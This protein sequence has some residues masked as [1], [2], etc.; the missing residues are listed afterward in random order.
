MRAKAITFV[1]A[2]IGPLMA[3]S[4]FP[5]ELTLKWKA[6]EVPTYWHNRLVLAKNS[7][8]VSSR[9]M[10]IGPSGAPAPDEADGLYI[11]KAET[12]EK[13]HL[14]TSKDAGGIA[15]SDIDG[16]NLPEALV[17]CY[18][19]SVY[20]YKLGAPSRP[21]KL[22]TG[23]LIASTPTVSDMDGDGSPEILVANSQG[24]L[25][26]F[27]PDGGLLWKYEEMRTAWIIS[28]PAVADLDGDA[29][30][31][32]VVG[33]S[34]GRNEG[35]LYCFN[36]QG[37]LL[38][39]F[40]ASGQVV[41][42]P[43]VGDIDKD[44][45][46]EIIFGS[47][48]HNLYCLNPDGSLRWKFPTG[49][50]ITSSPAL[51]DISPED[52]VEVMV[53]SKDSTV[54]CISSRGKK[55]WAFRT[56]GPVVSSPVVADLDGDGR[57][58]VVVGDLSGVIYVLGHFGIWKYE[59]DSEILS[60]P[61]VGDVDGD[62]KL[63]VV[64]PSKRTVYCFESPGA[65]RIAWAKFQGDSWNTGLLA[66]AITYGRF[67]ASGFPGTWTP[68]IQPVVVFS[69]PNLEEAIRDELG[70]PRGPITAK[71]LAEL[72]EL[73][74]SGRGIRDLSGI[75]RCINLRRLW[76]SGNEVEDIRP[77][78]ALTNL[79]ELYL[80]DNR[81][82]DIA[83][84]GNLTE[85]R[86][87]DLGDN[88]IE[89]VGSLKRLTNLRKLY[90]YNNSIE[91]VAPLAGLFGLK[92]L[93]LSNN[94]ISDIGPLANLTNLGALYLDD[95]LVQDI[96]PLANLRKIGEEGG[97]ERDG[98]VIHLGL[99]DNQITDIGP[100]LDNPGLGEGDGV[101]LRGN[102][103]G[104]ESVDI[105]RKL[106]AKGV[107]V[108]YEA[109]STAPVLK[110]PRQLNF[111]EVAVGDT[112]LR[113][114]EMANV[115]TDTLEVRKM[116][117]GRPTAEAR[118]SVFGLLPRPPLPWK[119]P[120]EGRKTIQLFFAPQR[121]GPHQDTLWVI[122]DDPAGPKGVA[123]IGMG[124]APEVVVSAGNVDFGPVQ[125][126]SYKDTLLSIYNRGNADLR[127]T[128][129]S[130]ASGEAFV[131]LQDPEG[132]VVSPDGSVPLR[133]RFLP[134]AV[135][136]F[137]DTIVIVT[138]APESPHK[139]PLAGEGIDK[140]PPNV[141]FTPPSPQ[142]VLRSDKPYEIR[143]TASDLSG[144]DSATVYY[145][146]GGERGFSILEMSGDTTFTATLSPTT[147]ILHRGLELY[148]KVVD[149]AGNIWQSP[150][151]TI[152]GKI[153]GK[154]IKR[155]GLT[156]RKK[157]QMISLPMYPEDPSPSAVLGDILG[158]YDDTK[159]RLFWWDPRKKT[160]T[161]CP[162]VPPFTPG[163]GYWLITRD[164]KELYTGPGVSVPPDTFEVTLQ[165]GWNMIGCPF[166]FP[167]GWNEV[168]GHETLLPE[169]PRAC[170]VV[171]GKYEFPDQ[172]VL[173]PWQGYAIYNPTGRTVTIK[174]P[175]LEAG[176][177]KPGSTSLLDLA[178]AS[179][180]WAVRIVAENDEV[181]DAYNFLGW[182]P[183]A[184]DTWDR[185]ERAELPPLPGFVSL[186]FDHRSWPD[187]PG[188]HTTDVRP[189]GR[190]RYTWRFFVLAPEGKVRLS[191]RHTGL[192]EGLRGR[193][194]DEGTGTWSELK[195]SGKYTFCSDG[196]VRAFKLV[197][198]P[199]GPTPE[200]Y[201]LS[202]FP[203]PFNSSVS[204]VAEVPEP[205]FEL[206][207]YDVRGRRVRTLA[208]GVPPGRYV[209]SWDGR[210]DEGRPAGSGIYILRLGEVSCK[211]ALI[212]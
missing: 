13:I 113:K 82:G 64:V 79:E 68:G 46:P 203:N 37:E 2:F 71:D 139:V 181:R 93:E 72:I 1:L 49:N 21:V 201:E 116:I 161:E 66:N 96:S 154:G 167:V 27:D 135:G 38:W 6:E 134:D 40:P 52:G 197:I 20:I 210:D 110:L 87:M 200:G 10:E 107:N 111:G 28:S 159:W 18:D 65:G 50:Q 156:L 133:V 44:G 192:P 190:K 85:L 122:S 183:E 205:G 130:L 77:L 92:V 35:F 204:I 195:P 57:L 120:P 182:M 51:A 41:S 99:S 36:S 176:T 14:K 7:V 100:L 137:R 89:D 171:D 170:T 147:Q 184:S 202:A 103:L 209:L 145:R 105:V 196:S 17:G 8:L 160:Y 129:V 101:D 125:L 26:C 102:P 175:P 12:G 162:D 188:L 169:L 23:Y 185:Y 53:G 114:V 86:E 76:L 136:E 163:R 131:L 60:S 90:L 151:Y 3:A 11:L 153:A 70:K 172:Y 45:R 9:G 109:P 199:S 16:D 128:G 83:P 88:L 78:G 84:L 24:N 59:A 95:N 155:P 108:L 189:A 31:E 178:E 180:G 47:Q 208:R 81:I 67:S 177:P 4:A 127:I 211:L 80:D 158:P 30:P 124:I 62:G 157:Y 198:E 22:N 54:Y 118:P 15:L 150:H 123:L 165:P 142:F 74:A 43:A 34:A 121:R 194:V 75:E 174:F 187:V 140:E 55:I 138:N 91:D 115:G 63:E 69:D 193:I 106:R 141:K 207:V 173:R 206:A 32:I 94:R 164:P 152:A 104:P 144:V 39:K 5:F 42:S 212:R 117:V 149:G 146:T 126:G 191:W 97:D 179:G 61:A 186:Y 58:E 48:D 112:S 143:L 56:K 166:A 98:V 29:S 148:I 25:F 132:S 168:E 119:L 33:N 73:D 19:G